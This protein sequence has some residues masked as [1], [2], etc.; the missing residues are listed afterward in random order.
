[1]LFLQVSELSSWWTNLLFGK[2]WE[3]FWKENIWRQSLK[4]E[5]LQVQE[6][7]SERKSWRKNFHLEVSIK[8]DHLYQE[9]WQKSQ[10]I[11]NFYG[12]FC[13]WFWQISSGCYH[14]SFRKVS[15]VRSL[16]DFWNSWWEINDSLWW[17]KYHN[18]TSQ[19][20]IRVYTWTRDEEMIVYLF[21][22]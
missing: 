12:Q 18:G 13:D 7:S 2:L 15:V 16:Q 22:F 17:R 14:F 10:E 4:S 20:A 1:M 11:V 5:G 19:S 6:M 21:I 3:K 8:V 9:I